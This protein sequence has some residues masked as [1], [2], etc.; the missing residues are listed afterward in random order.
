MAL[1]LL[2]ARFSPS[3]NLAPGASTV[4]LEMPK[5]HQRGAPALRPKGKKAEGSGAKS[6]RAGAIKS[7]R[8]RS[9]APS[10][11]VKIS[12]KKILIC[13]VSG[14]VLLLIFLTSKMMGSSSAGA[15]TVKSQE[16]QLR[17]AGG[18]TKIKQAPA[19]DASEHDQLAKIL[20]GADSA[21]KARR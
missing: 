17:G 12:A 10:A 13:L 9:G 4:C 16:K 20:E 15:G 1:A 5:H 7:P 21:K 3:C 6:G 11:K 18:D 19:D 14:L 2:S 8:G